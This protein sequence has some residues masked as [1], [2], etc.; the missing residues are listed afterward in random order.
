MVIGGKAEN[1]DSSDPRR[2]QGFEENTLGDRA[3]MSSLA[4]CH[5][6]AD[7]YLVGSRCN[8]HPASTRGPDVGR[9]EDIPRVRCRRR[10]SRS[11][12][13]HYTADITD[14]RSQRGH[15][16]YWAEMRLISAQSTF[17]QVFEAGAR[18]PVLDGR[19]TRRSC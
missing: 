5:G 6:L 4:D 10:N 3:G 12:F 19:S 2:L 18:G 1:R 17:S 9:G 16:W 8:L 15:K 7:H 11:H 13:V 14:S